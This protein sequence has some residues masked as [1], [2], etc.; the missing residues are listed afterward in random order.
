MNRGGPP[1]K[2]ARPAPLRNDSYQ[3]MANLTANVAAAGPIGAGP[4]SPS[5]SPN[6]PVRGSGSRFAS[7]RT[8]SSETITP[9]S[10][11]GQPDP[12]NGSYQSQRVSRVFDPSTATDVIRKE[13]LDALNRFVNN[14][15]SK[16][17]SARNG[18]GGASGTSSGNT[19]SSGQNGSMS[20]TSSQ[21]QNQQQQ[22]ARK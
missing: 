9:H 7:Q 22:Y 1:P 11:T 21:Q 3:N 17:G 16:N 5:L 20:R 19:S 12:S 18:S 4:A 13:G 6:V 14:M 8:S 10:S 2:F 15:G